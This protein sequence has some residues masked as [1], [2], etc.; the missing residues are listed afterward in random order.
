MFASRIKNDKDVDHETVV[1]EVIKR[2]MLEKCADNRPSRCS[3]GQLKRVL[4]ACELVSRPNIL[5]LD[6]PTSGLDSVTTW[7]LINLLIDLTRQPEPQAIVLTIHQPS[8]RLFNLLDMIYLMSCEGQCIYHGP[9]QAIVNKFKEYGLV[10]PNFTNPADFALEV[11]AKE[12]KG[13]ILLTLS[14]VK[15][16]EDMEMAVNKYEIKIVRHFRTLNNI[17]LLTDR[18][19]TT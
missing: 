12:H 3:G 7:Q 15:K 13:A 4:I 14:T 9:P 17:I 8:A 10:C 1:E 18:Y 16:I 19:V 2:L 11:A 5:I 6:E